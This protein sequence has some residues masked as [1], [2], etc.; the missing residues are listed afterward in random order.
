MRG[1]PERNKRTI[2]YRTFVERNAVTDDYGNL[3]G[4]YELVYS[5]K[6]TAARVN[7]SPAKGR[8]SSE[9]F[10]IDTAYTNT[11]TVDDVNCPIDEHS[12]L[13]I[14]NDIVKQS[15]DYIV[16]GVARGMDNVVY[17]IKKVDAG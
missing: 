12:I 2:Y 3:T 14:D 15:H 10:G 8:V 6:L 17:A 7:V 4:E 9:M 13:W 1:L 11:M 16:V 5:A